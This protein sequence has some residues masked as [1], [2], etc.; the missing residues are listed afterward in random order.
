MGVL[1]I[2]SALNIQKFASQQMDK[3]RITGRCLQLE[4]R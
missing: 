1:Q 3:I 2:V 4:A